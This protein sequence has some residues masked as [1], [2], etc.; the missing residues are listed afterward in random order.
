MKKKYN[1]ISKSNI[2]SRAT[3][4]ALAGLPIAYTVNILIFIPL[5]Y[6]MDGYPLWAIGAIGSIPFFL[7]S[8]FRMYFIDW[9]WFKYKI[10]I[11]PK[12]IIV[13]WWI[14]RHG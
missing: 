7:T 11:D 2:L 13:S 3:S 6:A 8:L 10:N 14:K 9:I 5:V 12:H 4:S 1:P